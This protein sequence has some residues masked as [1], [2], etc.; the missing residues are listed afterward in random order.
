VQI[1]EW[2]A[3]EKNT[4]RGFFD[5]TLSTGMVIKGC[6]LHEKNGSR[7]IGLP[8]QRFTDAQGVDC[9]KAIIYFTDR[10]AADRFRDSVLG[11]LDERLRSLPAAARGNSGK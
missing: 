1:S 2:T 7:W 5:L 6:T 10:R 9:Y 11:L 4:L 8:A 3:V